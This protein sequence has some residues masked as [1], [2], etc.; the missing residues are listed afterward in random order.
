MP[1]ILGISNCHLVGFDQVISTITL[2]D[3]SSDVRVVRSSPAALEIRSFTI[4]AVSTVVGSDG[5]S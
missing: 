2:Y 1:L 3:C 4:I 5:V